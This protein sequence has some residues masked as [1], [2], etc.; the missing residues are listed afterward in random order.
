MNDKTED[1]VRTVLESISLTK[2]ERDNLL[3]KCHNQEIEL[4]KL[5]AENDMLH[6]SNTAYKAERD[7]Y[8]RSCVELMSGL[9]NV[10]SVISDI[11]Q[12]ARDVPYRSNGPINRNVE[13]TKLEESIRQNQL[14]D[15][16][17][18]SKNAEWP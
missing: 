8:M 4:S 13:L 18:N 10:Q 6:T 17:A 5:K 3:A 14:A 9:T 2:L 12:K 15:K 16:I 1:Q 11:V 7:A